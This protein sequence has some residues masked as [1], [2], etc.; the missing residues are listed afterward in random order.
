MGAA[1]GLVPAL[2]TFGLSIPIG[3]AI[4]GGLG[5]GVAALVLCLGRLPRGPAM[6]PA[7]PRRRG[8]PAGGRPG[9]GMLRLVVH[10]LGRPREAGPLTAS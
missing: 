1:I 7:L 4:G 8:A 10:T 2:F 3:A 9:A 5:L 6:A